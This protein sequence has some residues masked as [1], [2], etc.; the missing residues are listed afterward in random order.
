[1][2]PEFNGQMSIEEFETYYWYKDELMEICRNYQLPTHGTKAELEQ[3]IKQFL[4]GKKVNNVR[5]QN[6]KIRKKSDGQGQITLATRLI[7]DGFKFNN[8][9]REFFQNYY[10]VPKFSFTKHMAAALREAERMNDYEMT[11]ADLIK[12]YEN[13]KNKPP[14]ESAEENTYEWNQF[15]KDFHNDPRTKGMQNKMKIAA[16]LWKTIRQ[17]P[18]SRKYTTELLNSYLGKDSLENDS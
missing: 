15:V 18:G 14:K 5:E 10:N 7:P 6:A 1:M 16:T 12:V 9:A 8:N 13:T 11:V 3:Y 4:T 2:R 17:R